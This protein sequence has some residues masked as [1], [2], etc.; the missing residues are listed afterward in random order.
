MIWKGQFYNVW[1]VDSWKLSCAPSPFLVRSLNGVFAVAENKWELPSVPHIFR[2]ECQLVRWIVSHGKTVTPNGLTILCPVR[3]KFPQQN[4]S[5]IT[6]PWEAGAK[7]WGVEMAHQLRAH[8][9][10]T[11]NL[12]LALSTH[13]GRLT[14]ACNWCFWPPSA[15]ALISTHQNT[16]T[17]AQFKIYKVNFAFVCTTKPATLTKCRLY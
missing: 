15:P 12:S 9:R 4:C 3:H 6:R 2:R 8:M 7:L 10:V 1:N 16:D 11:E 13:T 5:Q 17:Q 14:I